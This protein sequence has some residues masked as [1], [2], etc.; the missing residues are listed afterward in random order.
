MKQTKGYQKSAVKAVSMTI[1]NPNAA[2]ID[3]GDT[4]HAVAVPG[5]QTPVRTFGTMSCDLDEIVNWLQQCRIDTVAMEST[6]V[7]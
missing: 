7:Y 2:G 3:I 6:G 5:A 4:I 1:V